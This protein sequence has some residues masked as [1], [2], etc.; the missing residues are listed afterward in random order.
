MKQEAN[1]PAI[2][3]V[4]GIDNEDAA[5]VQEHQRILAQ[6]IMEGREKSIEVKED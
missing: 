2:S 6:H 3:V 5:S 1:N 4:S